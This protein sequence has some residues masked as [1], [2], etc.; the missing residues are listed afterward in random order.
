MFNDMIRARVAIQNL[1]KKDFYKEVA[2]I[3]YRDHDYEQLI[4]KFPMDG[5]FCTDMKQ[6]K[7]FLDTIKTNKKG[8][9][10][11][12]AVLDGLA[13]AGD[14]QWGNHDEKDLIVIHIFDAQP[15][16]NWPNYEDHHDQSDNDKKDCCC[17]SDKCT[18]KWPADV[19]EKYV[20]LG[21]H[22]HSIF[23][24]EKNYVHSWFTSTKRYNEGFEAVMK[25]KLGN[26]L[27]PDTSFLISEK[28]LVDI[29]INDIVIKDRY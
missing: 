4:E 18:R 26:K 6:V 25:Q 22:Y 13:A 29:K 16:G 10:P 3:I 23:T 20:T 5:T 27:C 11:N 24:H 14:L 17:C 19:F 9:S 21:L 1:V 8:T 15:H 2:I 28:K 12:E 7:L